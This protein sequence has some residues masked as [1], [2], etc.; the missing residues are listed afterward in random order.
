[1]QMNRQTD[2]N[3]HT[4]THTHTYRCV[5]GR[6]MGAPEEGRSVGEE[7]VG[8]RMRWRMSVFG[9]FHI[10]EVSEAYKVQGPSLFVVVD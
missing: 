7:C 5:C 1:M 8:E 2:V 6:Y 3:T 4:H 9:T 10:S